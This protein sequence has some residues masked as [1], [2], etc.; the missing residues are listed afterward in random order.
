MNL[1]FYGGAP[2]HALL[3]IY[4]SIL[5]FLPISPFLCIYF[6]IVI[7]I[8]LHFHGYICQEISPLFC[9]KRG[10]SKF[11][12]ISNFS[13]I[14][15]IFLDNFLK[16]Y[17]FLHFNFPSSS[18]Y[19]IDPIHSNIHFFILFFFL[20]WLFISIFASSPSS[21]AAFPYWYTKYYFV[22]LLKSVAS[23][24]C[25]AWTN[26]FLCENNWK[27]KYKIKNESFEFFEFYG[28]FDLYWFW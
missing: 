3:W 24:L 20:V 7:D 22:C 25:N 15:G 9:V 10:S 11:L 13:I 26:S 21:T 19:F 18:D 8:F 27:T 2:F 17:K 16:I 1:H 4:F 14:L 12:G 6:S 28:K 23:N 5:T